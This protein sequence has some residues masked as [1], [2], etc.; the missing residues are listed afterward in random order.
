MEYIKVVINQ[1]LR[2]IFHVF[3]I[4]P[5]KDNRIL[6]NSYMGRQYSCNPRYISEYLEK[7]YPGIYE[8]VWCFK[9]PEKYTSLRERGIEICKIHSLRFYWYR[10][11]ARVLVFN[12]AMGAEAPKRRGQY[13]INTWHGG[14]GGYKKIVSIISSRSDIDSVRSNMD[15]KS[16]DL[17][18]AS[19]ETSLRNTVRKAFNHQGECLHGT[20]RND[21]FINMDRADIR[22]N[23]CELLGIRREA[24]ILLYAPTFRGTG[25]INS[26]NH[27][28]GLDFA[29]LY[30]ALKERFGGEWA[31]LIRY[32]FLI[33]DYTI[34]AL[35]YLMDATHYSDM[36]ELLYAADVLVTDYSS[37]IWDYSFT[38]RPC[39]LFC[40]DLKTY[41]HNRGFNR[42]IYEWG[43]PVSETNEELCQQILNWD[44]YTHQ[45]NMRKH[46]EQNGSFE[47]GTATQRI[48]EIIQKKCGI[49][50]K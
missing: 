32:H 34:P 38:N 10:M 50:W 24:H 39:F 6:F 5:I 12:A 28:Y 18:C 47:D 16:V 42:P 27:D 20:P 43:F 4:F 45:E 31:I 19:S 23:V 22:D 40:S 7:N 17:Y 44:A 41:E 15:K 29:K 35:P 25:D 2:I 1:I 14:G 9:N 3:Y 8:L 30:R 11:T 21:M 48:C 36:Q 33:R 26:I 13:Y 46:H 49:S 37:S